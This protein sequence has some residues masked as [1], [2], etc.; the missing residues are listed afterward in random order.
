MSDKIETRKKDDKLFKISE[1]TVKAVELETRPRTVQLYAHYLVRF[2]NKVMQSMKIQKVEDIKYEHLEVFARGAPEKRIRKRSFI[3]TAL[4]KY[5]NVFDIDFIPLEEEFKRKVNE[6][7]RHPKHK[8]IRFQMSEGDLD[9]LVDG[10]KYSYMKVMPKKGEKVGITSKP[11]P[12]DKLER[13]KRQVLILILYYG[14]FRIS[15][16]LLLHL[17]DIGLKKYPMPVYVPA[18]ITKTDEGRIVY[19]HEEVA[20]VLKKYISEAKIQ[21]KD[22]VFSLVPRD[23]DIK[24]IKN[25]RYEISHFDYYLKKYADE[26]GLVEIRDVI[27]NHKLRHAYAHWLKFLGYRTE[28]IQERMGHQSLEM[29]GKYIRDD[30]EKSKDKFIELVEKRDKTKRME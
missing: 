25:V 11:I 10:V 29:T 5:F 14:G 3:F 1:F 13:Q 9:L 22:Y 7:K 24:T 21:K 26:S 28:E 23:K 19:L 20:I 2:Q 4:K 30:E 17:S 27:S 6:K 16:L 8:P 15:E 12:L 18:E